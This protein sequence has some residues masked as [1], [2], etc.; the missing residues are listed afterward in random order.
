MNS[1]I[2]PTGRELDAAVAREVFGHSYQTMDRICVNGRWHDVF[3]RLRCR[4]E[5]GINPADPPSGVH[6]GQ[7]QLPRYSTDITAAMKVE[8]RIEELG[9]TLR[10]AAAIYEMCSGLQDLSI[11]WHMIHASPEMRCRAALLAVEGK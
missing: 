3:T 2:T 8:D 4:I 7:D 10:Y 1:T 11:D 5:L 9:L 6:A